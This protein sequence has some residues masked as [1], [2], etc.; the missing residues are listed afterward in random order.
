MTKYKIETSLELANQ[1][2]NYKFI[3]AS[4]ANLQASLG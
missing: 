1:Y 3:G 2:A 4:N